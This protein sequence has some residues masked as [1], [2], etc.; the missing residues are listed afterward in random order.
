MVIR[1]KPVSD[2]YLH[3]FV[4][5]VCAEENIHADPAAKDYLVSLTRPSIRSM[6]NYLEK[7]KILGLPLT[8][9]HLRQTNTDIPFTLLETFFEAVQRADKKEAQ[10]ILSLYNDG[11]SVM[12]TLD[13]CYEYVKVSTMP[14]LAKYK[15][16]KIICKY[17]AIFNMI[18]EHPLEL[19]FFLEDCINISSDSRN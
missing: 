11:Y 13:A 18:H 12:D 8:V 6:L 5:R 2:A 10:C 7:Y 4:D 16:I 17:I 19:F 14:D 15:Y 1:L 9:A 3:A